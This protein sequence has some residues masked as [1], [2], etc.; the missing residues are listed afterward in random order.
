MKPIVGISGITAATT[1]MVALAGCAHDPSKDLRT[2]END[3]TSA[4]VKARENVNAIDAN[5]ADT[6]AKAV[7]EGRTN[8]SD[9]EKKLADA[10][11]KLDTD[12]KNLTASSKSSLDQLDSQASNLKMK[13]DTLPPAKKNQFDALW[14]QYT[15]M[16]GQVQD[17]ISGLS[18]VP[19]DSWTSASKGLTN[20]LN[21]LS[22]TVGKLG[23]LF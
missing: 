1:L 3:L 14:D 21:S 8:V 13:A 7:S 22:G 2:A 20:N 23:K 11:A 19:N 18:A 12:R 17:Q 5:Y 10:N 4:Q 6:R 16:R 9:A 15:G